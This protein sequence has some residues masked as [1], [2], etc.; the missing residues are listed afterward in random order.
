[1]QTDQNMETRP[2]TTN[3]KYSH[4]NVNTCI[5]P[6]IIQT[7][8]VYTDNLQAI[9]M[10]SIYSMC[11]TL[12]AAFVESHE[13]VCTHPACAHGART[14]EYSWTQIQAGS[15]SLTWKRKETKHN[16]QALHLKP[17]SQ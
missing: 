1:M 11:I 2:N 13:R 3:S 16:S 15:W 14:T 6:K 9:Y 4:N 12:T 17:G 8:A 5:I 10:H 7:N